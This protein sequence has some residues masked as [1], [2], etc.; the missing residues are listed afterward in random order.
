MPMPTATIYPNTTAGAIQYLKDDSCLVIPEKVRS[1]RDPKVDGVW[2]L[3][4]DGGC[5]I[6][7]LAGEEDPWGNIRLHNDFEAEDTCK[8]R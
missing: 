7:Y 5:A 2:K 6:V 8:L 4:L 1:K 3:W